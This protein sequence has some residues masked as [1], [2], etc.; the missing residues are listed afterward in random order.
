MRLSKLGSLTV[1]LIIAATAGSTRGAETD[2]LVLKNGYVQRE[3]RRVD[4][5][6]RTIRFARADGSDAIDVQSDE[7]HILP[8]DSERG[9]TVANY[10]A[11]GPPV[12]SEADGVMTVRNPDRAEQVLDVPF[13][14]SVYF[15]GEA[16]QDYRARVIYPFVEVMPWKLVSGQPIEI[17]VPG[18]SVMVLE[19]EPGTSVRTSPARPDPLPASRAE[20]GDGTFLL[21]LNIPDEDFARYDLLVQT[22][23]AVDTAIGIDGKSV[24]PDQRQQVTRWT[25][26]RYDL[27]DHRGHTITVNG[28]RNSADGRK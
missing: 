16:G 13:D 6:W 12:R 4:G 21:H 5:S 11:T 14:R 18:D 10:V 15:R 3:L 8:L 23:A 26:A 19:I 25:I 2:S 20:S 24:T 22:W 7:F 9:W 28:S 17:N 1:T 27:R